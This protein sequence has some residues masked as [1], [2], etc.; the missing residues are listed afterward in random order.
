M[1]FAAQ[2]V[3][4][5]NQYLKVGVNVVSMHIFNAYRKDGMGL[6]SFTDGEDQEQY[7]YTQFEPDACRW[8]FPCFD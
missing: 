3:N 8:V 1:V 2:Q 5:S 4:L 7:L 6:H